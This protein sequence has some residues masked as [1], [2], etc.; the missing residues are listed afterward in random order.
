MSDGGLGFTGFSKSLSW[1]V[2]LKGSG[3][4]YPGPFGAVNI[5]VLP[6]S[7]MSGRCRLPT[8]KFPSIE[9]HVL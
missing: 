8:S 1:P 2:L 6:T 4:G 3:M 7:G 5:P 9:A